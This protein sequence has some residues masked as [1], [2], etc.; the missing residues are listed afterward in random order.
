VYWGVKNR[1]RSSWVGQKKKKEEKEALL[2]PTL[3]LSLFLFQA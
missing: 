1:Y 3:S 2:R